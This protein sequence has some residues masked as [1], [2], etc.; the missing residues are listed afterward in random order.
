[1]RWQD[2]RG[3]REIRNSLLRAAL[4]AIAIALFVCA[5]Q[6][7]TFRGAISGTVT[8]PSGAVIPNAQVKA[9]E[10]ATGLEHNTVTTSASRR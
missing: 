5:G 2:H 10:T 8:D 7:Q 1:M 6:A 9:T 4:S 3:Y